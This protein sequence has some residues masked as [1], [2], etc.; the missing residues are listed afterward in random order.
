MNTFMFFIGAMW[1]F[2]AALFLISLL[3]IGQRLLQRLER[4]LKPGA[5]TIAGISLPRRVIFIL[6]CG[7]YAAVALASAFQ[8]SFSSPVV[9][10]FMIVLP[11]LYLLLGIWDRQF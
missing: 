8:H 1:F 10:L 2:M 9:V 6:F 4:R 11:A 7:L 5:K 3:P